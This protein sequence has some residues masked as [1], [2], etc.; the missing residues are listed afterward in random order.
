MCLLFSLL[1]LKVAITENLL[2]EENVTKE[3]TEAPGTERWVTELGG[4]W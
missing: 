4:P 2:S 1:W 3:Q